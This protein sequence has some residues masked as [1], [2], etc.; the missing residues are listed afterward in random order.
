[1]CLVASL[2]T[3]PMT[4]GGVGGCL[5]VTIDLCSSMIVACAV[6]ILSLPCK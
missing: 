2:S 5:M 1:M 6:L 4:S 3:S